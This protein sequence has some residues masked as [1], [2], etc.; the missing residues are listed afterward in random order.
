M[1][2]ILDNKQK[3]S[4]RL[5]DD[6]R[7]FLLENNG[8]FPSPACVYFEENA[9]QTASDVLYFFAVGDERPW[10]SL[11]WHHDTYSGR[12]PKNTLPIARDSCGN[13]WLLSVGSD[14]AGSIFFWDHGSSDTFDETDLGNWPCVAT[15]FTH[16]RDN[17]TA[18]DPSA[19]DKVLPS[20]YAL[21]KQATDG[22][23]KKDAGFSTRANPDFVWHCAYSD[24]RNVRME[25][26]QYEVH[27]FATHTDGY[28]RLRAI[29]GVIEEGHTRLPE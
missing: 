2:E 24:D 22:M 9:Q 5:P 10:A 23:A 15:S 3:Y 12:L 20:R 19:E 7:K 1:M 29:Q 25:F 18:Y 26:V 11:Q 4:C 16:F 14:N 21:V 6:Y 13:L 27:A 28:S 17:L 8:G